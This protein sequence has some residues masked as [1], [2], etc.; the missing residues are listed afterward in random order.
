MPRVLT[1]YLLPTQHNCFNNNGKKRKLQSND[2]NDYFESYNIMWNYYAINFQYLAISTNVYNAEK[3]CADYYPQQS[4][5]T[6]EQNLN[7]Q[8][9][10][11]TPFRN[12]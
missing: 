9:D 8:E 2:N 12:P 7:K 6:P 11:F 4:I 3:R 1:T 10:P 5:E